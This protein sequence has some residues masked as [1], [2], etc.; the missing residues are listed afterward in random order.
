[1]YK[2]IQLDLKGRVGHA[3]IRI[4]S[5]KFLTPDVCPTHSFLLLNDATVVKRAHETA[6]K[7]RNE[8]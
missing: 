5:P 8:Y 7:E 3:S 2:H 6:L 1:M 4:P